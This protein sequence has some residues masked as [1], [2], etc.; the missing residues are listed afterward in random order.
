MSK[1][2]RKRNKSEGSRPQIVST[3]E[4][5]LI[6][7]QLEQV[8]RPGT[9]P[10]KQAAVITWAMQFKNAYFHTARGSLRRVFPKPSGTVI[11]SGVPQSQSG[12]AMLAAFEGDASHEQAG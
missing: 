9:D 10:L 8:S 6:R 5:M 11:F 4:L 3:A 2:N 12:R 1:R 7:E